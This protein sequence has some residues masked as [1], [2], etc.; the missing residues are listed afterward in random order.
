MMLLKRRLS[1][2]YSADEVETKKEYSA[3]EGM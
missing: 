1:N 2:T 3:L